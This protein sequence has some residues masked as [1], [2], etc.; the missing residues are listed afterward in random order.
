MRVLGTLAALFGIYWLGAAWGEATGSMLT[1]FYQATVLGRLW[2]AA[3]FAWLVAS[4]QVPWGLGMLGAL[5]AAGAALTALAL[6]KHVS[7]DATG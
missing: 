4:R 2:L 6:R 1:G 3:V 5:N 7:H